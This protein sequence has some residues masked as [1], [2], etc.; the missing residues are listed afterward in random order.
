VSQ[1]FE[2]FVQQMFIGPLWPAS[3]LVCL[4][5]V[6]TLLA[7]IGLIDF[8]MDAPD[9]DLDPG[10]G[11]DATPANWD[12]WQGIGAASLRWT[13]FGRVPVI[14]WGSVFAVSFWGISY[15]LWHAFDS[16]R[17]APTWIPSLLLTTRNFVIAVLATKA[18]TEP[19]IKFFLRGPTYDEGTLIGATCEVSSLE[20][21]PES[22]QGKF[23]TNAA[24][25]LLNIRTDGPHITKGTEVKIIGFDRDKRIYQVTQ[26]P[27]ET[28]S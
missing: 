6:Y 27:A 16:A 10:L 20:A 21:T 3:I 17:Y 23:R 22:G 12:F 15:A 5:I 11:A 25:L 2:Q 7:M 1:F 9:V 18:I 8:G 19:L 24:P 4:L 13:N 28:N 14:I 26:L